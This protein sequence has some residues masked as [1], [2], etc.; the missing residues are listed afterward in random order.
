MAEVETPLRT[1]TRPLILR[2]PVALDG[3]LGWFV[4][5]VAAPEP[6]DQRRAKLLVVACHTAGVLS[7]VSLALRA[8][9]HALPGV[10]WAVTAMATSVV[11]LASPFLMRRASTVRAAALPP[12]VALALAL[13]VLATPGGGVDAPVVS[14]VP[15]MPL[16]AAYFIGPRGAAWLAA[17]LAVE[18]GA[19]AGAGHFGWVRH[20]HTPEVVK[21]LLVAAFLAVTAF[22]ARVYDR[23]RQRFEHQLQELSERLREVAIRDPLTGAYNRRHLS[24]RLA[25]EL[26]YSRRHRTP[27]SVVMMDVDHFKRVNDVHGHGAGDA[28]LTHIV[29]L[30]RREVRQEDLL[31]RFG[32]E[33]FA[34]VLRDT[35]AARSEIVAERLRARIEGTE[36][37]HAGR[38]IPVTLS[39]GCASEIGCDSEEA[40]IGI[41]DA[42]L[43]EAKRRGR[44]CVVGEGF[45]PTPVPVS[46]SRPAA[47]EVDRRRAR[48]VPHPSA[49]HRVSR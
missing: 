34:L 14:M 9:L 45:T 44:N 32:G 25:C 7:A 2:L 40:L 38:S 5:R 20:H 42:R 37:T 41:A 15:A 47:E 16:I 30:L 46:S 4:E 36:L 49:L 10:T 27:L 26:A 22:I 13:P 21:A 18:V 17:L 11:M 43:Y 29:Q 39:L 6:G 23:E 12:I 33:E 48:A 35:D 31:A 24:E 28:M 19:M 3:Y 1:S 8:A